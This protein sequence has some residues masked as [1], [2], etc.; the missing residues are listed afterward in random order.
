MVF[1]PNLFELYS[2]RTFE[3]AFHGGAVWRL[4]GVCYTL[5]HLVPTKDACATLKYKRMAHQ[6]GISYRA[7]QRQQEGAALRDQ[8]RERRQASG[9]SFDCGRE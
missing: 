3:F 9:P 8:I 7:S 1:I 5:H 4:H 6:A 2:H